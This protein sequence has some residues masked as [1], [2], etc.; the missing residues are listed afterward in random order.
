ML[1]VEKIGIK[2]VIENVW[3]NFLISLMEVV[4]YIDEF[5]SEMIGWYFD[6]GNIICYGWVD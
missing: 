5:D 4:C 6:V 1:I 2:I 3:N